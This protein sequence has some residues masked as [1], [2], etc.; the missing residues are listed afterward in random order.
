M[1][2]IVFCLQT[3]T[4]GGVEKELITVLKQIHNQFDITLLLLHLED[5][6]ILT[7]IPDDVK[8]INIGIEKDYYYGSTLSLVNQRIKRGKFVE[9]ANI[10]LKWCLRIG[11]TGSNI[12]TKAIPALEDEFDIAIC[13]H[14]HSPLMFKYVTDKINAKKK[15]AWIH[16]DFYVTGYPIQ[17]LKKYVVAYDEFVAVSKKVEREF[18]E[19]CPWYCGDIST[20]YNYLD[21]EEIFELSKEEINDLVFLNEKEVKILTVGRFSEQKG[22]DIAIKTAALLKKNNL[23]FHWFLIGYGELEEVYRNLIKEYDVSD[24]FTILGRKENPYP[25]I[26]NC[27]IYVQT[28]R[29]EAYSLVMIEAKILRKPIVCTDFDGADEQIENDVNGII[30]PLNDIKVL[31][32]A[33]SGLIMEPKIR[34][35]FAKQLDKWSQGEVLQEIVKHFK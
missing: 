26:R 6:D 35:N 10:A 11:T 1:K 16:N 23:K 33:I 13:Y 19:R 31:S 12:N 22:I 5:H 17:R 7:E 9:A 29:H 21:A 28:S 30:V 32:E 4:L 24:C 15:I 3:M 34:E 8:I 2:K 14:I 18:R 20:A 27:D 25:Y